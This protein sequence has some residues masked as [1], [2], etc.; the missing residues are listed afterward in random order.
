MWAHLGLG[1]AWGIAPL[2]GWFAA[3]PQL[4]PLSHH[5]PAFLLS[6]FCI[7]WVA[8]FDVIYALLDQGFDRESGIFSMP[9]LLGT[10][11][12]LRVSRI[13]HFIAAGF[14]GALVQSYL[15][16]PLSFLFLG[17]AGGLLL[18]SHWKVSTEPL[19]PS[20]IDFAFF[21]VNAA[22]GFV[23]FLLIFVR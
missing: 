17:L 10:E 15:H 9:A 13:F 11:K 4:F 19:G 23:V 3:Y 16:Q 8:G 2:G 6:L 18:L 1:I 7:F 12:A 5:A 22:L 21:K 14:L 20:V